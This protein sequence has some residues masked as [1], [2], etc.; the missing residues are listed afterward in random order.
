M[1]YVINVVVVDNVNLNLIMVFNF[2][3][4]GGGF[5]CLVENF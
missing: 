3:N 4:I 1:F 2:F 5:M